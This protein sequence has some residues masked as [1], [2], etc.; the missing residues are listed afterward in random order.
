MLMARMT[1]TKMKPENIFEGFED[2]FLFKSS[3]TN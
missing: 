3:Q 2:E 1:I